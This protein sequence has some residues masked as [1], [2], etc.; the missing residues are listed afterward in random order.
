MK[1]PMT[2]E[3]LAVLALLL[4]ASGCA[5]PFPKDLMAQVDGTALYAD[6]QKEPERYRGKVLMVGGMIVETKNLQE[7]TQF[8]VLQK[9]LEGNGRPR[10]TDESGGRFLVLSPQFH[11]AAVFQRGRAITFIAEVVGQR[12]QPLGEISY[13]Y[14]VLKA[15]ETHLWSPYAGPRFS[16][17]IGVYRGF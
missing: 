8:E 2:I 12:A 15:R 14:P 1:I 11:D 7:G 3:R 17:G 16:I 6:V 13:R 9:P 10:E 4:L 5:P